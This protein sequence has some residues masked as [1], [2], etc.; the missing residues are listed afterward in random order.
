MFNDRIE[1]SIFVYSNLFT[2]SS[3]SESCQFWCPDTN[4]SS[5]ELHRKIGGGRFVSTGCIAATTSKQLAKWYAYKF[6]ILIQRQPYIINII[7][8]VWLN[9][10]SFY[11]CVFVGIVAHPGAT[12][13][14]LLRRAAHAAAMRRERNNSSLSDELSMKRHRSDN[15]PGNNNSPDVINHMPQVTATDFSTIK[16]NNNNT[17]PMKDAERGDHYS[18]ER[19]YHH[20]ITSIQSIQSIPHVIW[21]GWYASEQ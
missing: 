8:M 11:L 20:S 15:G 17:P 16:H 12:V 18:T 1:N 6:C 7:Y 10:F 4:Q 3:S 2:V 5:S 19:M 14:Q 13:N 9:I 21:Y